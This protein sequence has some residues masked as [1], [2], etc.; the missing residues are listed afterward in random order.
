M[1]HFW[2]NHSVYLMHILDEVDNTNRE[3]IINQSSKIVPKG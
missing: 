3:N 2:N 1:K